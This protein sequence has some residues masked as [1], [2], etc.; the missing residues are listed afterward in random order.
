MPFDWRHAKRGA[1]TSSP[2]MKTPQRS[3]YMISGQWADNQ[4]AENTLNFTH[5]QT[6]GYGI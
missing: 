3:N 1:Q 5:K 2:G 4:R 6:L